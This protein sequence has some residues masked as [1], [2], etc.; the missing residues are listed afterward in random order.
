ED[1]DEDRDLE[2]I[3]VR[4][5]AKEVA[6]FWPFVLRYGINA[7]SNA[8]LCY[9]IAQKDLDL[10]GA[11]AAYSSATSLAIGL[12]YA[13]IFPL[14]TLMSD[15]KGQEDDAQKKYDKKPTEKNLKAIKRAQKKV[16]AIWRQGFI[17]SSLLSVPAVVF[18][19]TAS[20]VFELMKQSQ[21]V[22]DN[23]RL[24]LAYS[25]GGFAA[26]VFY[27]WT[28]RTVTGLGVKKSILIADGADNLI[29]LALAYAFLN[30]KFGAPELGIAGVGLA[31]SISKV[32][33]VLAHLTYIYTSPRCLGFDY[34]KYNLFSLSGPFF[35]KKKSLKSCSWPVFLM[36]YRARSLRLAR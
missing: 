5:A 13:S 7:G 14:M 31:Y 23:S 35:N 1:E 29:E 27:R 19:M 20:P 12:L 2:I 22:V 10:L 26:D 11:Y 32:F 16:R 4:Q 3:T 8:T 6:Q 34:T 25:S 33:T 15:A 28:A 21:V 17:F 9:A 24:F 36:V 18:G 30:G